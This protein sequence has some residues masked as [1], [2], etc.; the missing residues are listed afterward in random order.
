MSGMATIV[1]LLITKTIPASTVTTTMIWIERE[2]NGRGVC[3]SS[4]A[5]DDLRGYGLFWG[6]LVLRR[7]GT[8]GPTVSASDIRW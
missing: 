2:G 4:P 6:V 7:G 1:R 8:A 3:P 5:L